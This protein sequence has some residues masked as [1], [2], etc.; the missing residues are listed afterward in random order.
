MAPATGQ[1]AAKNLSYNGTSAPGAASSFGF[2][3]THTGNTS[4]PRLF[5][6]NGAP[7]HNRLTP[8]PSHGQRV[9]RWACASARRR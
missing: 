1:V 7:L 3:A 9:S 6:L 5:S 8:L 2:Q 4:L